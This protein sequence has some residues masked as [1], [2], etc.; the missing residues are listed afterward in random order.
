M[1]LPEMDYYRPKPLINYSSFI[2]VFKE[3]Y[4]IL[5]VINKFKRKKKCFYIK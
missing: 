4:I 1:I 5:S 2:N 3:F